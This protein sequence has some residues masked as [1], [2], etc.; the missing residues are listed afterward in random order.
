MILQLSDREPWRIC[1]S[2]FFCVPLPALPSL[3]QEAVGPHRMISGVSAIGAL[4]PH[5]YER[6]GKS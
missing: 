1:A 4:W 3:E 6:G 2:L 5:W